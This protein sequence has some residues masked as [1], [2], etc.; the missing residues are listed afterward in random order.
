MAAVDGRTGQSG[1]PPDR[2]CR[3]SGAPPRHP[4]VRVREQSTV[5]AVVFLW[6]R[7]VRC[8]TGHFLVCLWLLLWLLARTVHAPESTV[9][10][11]SCCSAGAPDSSVAHRT[12]RW[13]IAERAWRNPRVAGLAL[14]GPST[15]DTV[16]WH[17]GQSIAPDHNTLGFFA[18]LNLDP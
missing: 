2:H 13:I 4:T 5:G 7:I 1:A 11:V 14:Y 18:P 10:R 8:H 6:H 17:T 3:L 16:W 12:V 9:A 15:P